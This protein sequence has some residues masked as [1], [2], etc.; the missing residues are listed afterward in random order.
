MSIET[1]DY[2]KS[3]IGVL[4]ITAIQESITLLIFTDDPI[5]EKL[6]TNSSP[7][8]NKCVQQLEEYFQGTRKKFEIPLN[9]K[10]TS[11]Q[12]K[13]WKQ[14]VTIPYGKTSTYLDIAK[15]ICNDRASQA[16]GQANGKNPIAIIIP[17][18]RVIGSNK[19]LTGYAGGLWRKK[20]LLD[21]EKQSKTLKKFLI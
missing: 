19:N 6:S 3:P 18:H 20:W 9:P 12:K 2:Y 8:I 21:H 7:T 11:F 4:K 10:G 15:S 5:K 17:C 16:I 13:V 14:L 1:V